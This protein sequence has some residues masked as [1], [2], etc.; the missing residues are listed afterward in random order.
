M[1]AMIIDGRARAA[2]LRATIKTQVAAMQNPPGLAFILVGDDPAS[3]IYV[4]GK[5]K[6]C[7][8]AG[9]TSQVHRLANHSTDHEIFAIIDALN[10]NPDVHGILV[11]MPLPKH[12]DGFAV[13]SRVDA[14]KDVDGLHPLNLG[15]LMAG[16]PGLR[17][18]TPSGVMIL[19]QDIEPYLTGMHAVVVGRSNLVGKPMAQMLLA[20]GCTVT[21]CHSHTHDLG[22]ITRQADI[23]VAAAGKPGLITG[24]MVKPQAIVIDVGITRV[25][26]YLDE[27]RDLAQQSPEAP[28]STG[29]TRLVGD[30]DFAGVSNVARAITPVPGGVGPMTIA[31]LLQNTVTAAIIPARG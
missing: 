28:A 7:A 25:T 20:A 26:R 30:V 23:L 13:L 19:L 2:Y 12:L 17:P 29:A 6:A 5:I 1:A 9:I 14:A 15:R 22:N 11:Q 8:E 27:G 21:M 3:V 24:T 31:C 18:C 4:N 10:A 16:Q